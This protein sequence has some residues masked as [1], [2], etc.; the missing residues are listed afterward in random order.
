MKFLT[1][2]KL[3]DLHLVIGLTILAVLIELAGP[4]ITAFRLLPGLLLALILPG[5]A[6]T[7]AIAPQKPFSRLELFFYSLVL[8]LVAAII[9]GLLLNLSSGG[10][11]TANW[12]L[13]L[14]ALT[15][16][17]SV[18]ALTVAPTEESKPRFNLGLQPWQLLY[19]I[20]TIVLVIGGFYFSAN[21]A[22][23]PTESGTDFSQFWL[24]PSSTLE[25]GESQVVVG[26]TNQQTQAQTYNV[27]L[28]LNGKQINSWDNLTLK[29]GQSWK[30]LVEIP[31]ATSSNPNQFQLAQANL[32]L[33][34]KP[35]QIFRTVNLQVNG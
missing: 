15:I 12:S 3:K 27:R 29:P 6:L 5:Y 16:A 26:I 21:A 2:A 4:D 1:R 33:S 25:T 34:A 14:G 20:T 18:Y 22:E 17:A 7:R 9:S 19:L 8:S 23:R 35:G 32:Y 11:N 13:W 30:S 31:R 24:V 28:V 10:L